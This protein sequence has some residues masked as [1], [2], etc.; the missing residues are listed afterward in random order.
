MNAI[1]N[2]RSVREFDLSKR[3]SKAELKEL[4]R[5]AEAA[6]SARNQR[7]RE[8][9]IIDDEAVIEELSKVS[10]G[11]SVVARCNTV[12]AVL[13]KNPEEITTPH[14]QPQDLACAVENILI[15][16]T[17]H[18]WGSCY[19]G[20]YPLEDRMKACD[21]ILGVK[22]KAFTFALIALGYPK[23]SNVFFDKEK[24]SEDLIHYNRY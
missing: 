7:G 21:S 5:L 19:I 9:I 23:N 17:E 2:R 10:P 12:I 18:N 14:M 16:A 6:P 13:G 1:I 15:A 11:A 20:I 8:Y 22:N 3:I 4:C 24:P